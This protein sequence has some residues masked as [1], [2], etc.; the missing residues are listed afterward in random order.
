MS[1]FR[2]NDDVVADFMYNMPN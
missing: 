1:S 2:K